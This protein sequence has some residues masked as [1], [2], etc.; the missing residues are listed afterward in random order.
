M[1]LRH[2]AVN[3]HA[4]TDDKLQRLQELGADVAINYKTEDFVQRCKEESGGTGVDVI[5]DNMGG[6]YLGKNVDVLATD[7]RL[8]ILGLQ[9]GVSGQLDIRAMLTKRLAVMSGGLR[10]QS[11]E[12]K[13]MFVRDTVQHVWPLIEAG[14]I[15]SVVECQVALSE[16]ARAHEL[17]DHKD[18]FGVIVL[19]V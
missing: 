18:H 6:S 4:G 17:L 19:T 10:S 2:L 14:K 16:A 15:R 7:G 1:W 11:K 3:A 13:A 12:K 8:F 9:G 5:L